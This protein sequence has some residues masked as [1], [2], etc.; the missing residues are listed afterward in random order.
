MLTVK[1]GKGE[2]RAAILALTDR[3]LERAL[4][5]TQL[6][7]EETT[8]YAHEHCKGISSQ[9]TFAR[10]K[11]ILP[12]IWT[13]YS[14]FI[15]IMAA[16][17]VVREIGPLMRQKDRDPAVIVGDENGRFLIPLLSGH[18]GGANAWANYLAHREGSVAVI[19][20][21]TDVQGLVAPDE[22]ARRFGWKVEPL[23]NL[24]AINRKLLETE[25]LHFF[26][27]FGLPLGHPWLND[28]HYQ[29]SSR[30]EAD[31]LV[32]AFPSSLT[33]A[34]YL[35]P[36]VLS[37]GIGCR[38]GV[39]TAVVLEA[40]DQALAQI[41]ASPSALK[42]LYSIELK[43]G[44]IGLKE[45]A[46]RLKVAFVTFK[47]SDIQIMNQKAGTQRSEFVQEKIGVDGV[48]EAASLL[49]TEHGR[50]ILFK[51]IFKG[52]TIAI[53][54]DESLSLVSDPAILST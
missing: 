7:P 13:E 48:C 34:L 15:F 46:A 9:Q 42:G 29:E 8:V 40:V 38:R 26:S 24:P 31:I 2:V 47:A 27:D 19:T 52:I 53:S 3:G 41:G 21:A 14:L 51:T 17:I 30:S 36:R 4:D 5:L 25:R 23:A 35:I 10:L 32:S 54:M 45:A 20:T 44:E 39:G 37:L 28:P 43:A 33:S 11:D 49:G 12:Q 16:G 6:L 18:L 1:G 50:I 22:Y